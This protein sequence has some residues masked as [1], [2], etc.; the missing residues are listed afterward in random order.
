[1]AK[2]YLTEKELQSVIGST[3]NEILDNAEAE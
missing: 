1:M 2:N 3:L